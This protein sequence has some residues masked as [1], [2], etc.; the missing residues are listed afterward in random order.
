M[1]DEIRRQ[2]LAEREK[3]ERLSQWFSGVEGVSLVHARKLAAK[4]GVE[5]VF[6]D[7]DLPR[8]REG[9]YRF[10]GGIRA[11]VARGI[12]FAP[13]ADL[14]WMETAKPDINEARAFAEG[15]R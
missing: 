2:N 15:N 12:A 3:G 14:L 1:A 9:F 7:W 13:Y 11:C 10:E 6:F 8:T 5:N 4:L